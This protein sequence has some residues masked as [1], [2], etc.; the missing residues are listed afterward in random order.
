MGGGR[1][2]EELPCN[3]LLFLGRWQRPGRRESGQP[4]DL[5]RRP[6]GPGRPRR[7]QIQHR[8][9]PTP[10]PA[11]ILFHAVSVSH[12]LRP[13][14]GVFLASSSFPSLS[15]LFVSSLTACMQRHAGAAA[16]FMHGGG[17][18]SPEEPPPT[19]VM[20]SSCLS[21]CLTSGGLFAASSLRS[22]PR[23]PRPL[24]PRVFFVV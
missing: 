23:R 9:P 8:Y 1:R 24:F 21:A 19:Q 2:E 5:R 10:P 15:L 14:T 16:W 22:D 11:A 3:V 17:D 18:G 4:G 6:P 12:L 7:R 20:L 13:P